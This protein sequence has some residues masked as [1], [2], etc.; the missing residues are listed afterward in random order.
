MI[1]FCQ[2]WCSAEPFLQ[3][4]GKRG[5]EI[6]RS[7][8]KWTMA[9]PA[10]S[11]GFV[12]KSSMSHEIL[13]TPCFQQSKW[14]T[15][16]A[17][18]GRK[19]P[20]PGKTKQSRIQTATWVMSLVRLWLSLPPKV[21]GKAYENCKEI[22]DDDPLRRGANQTSADLGWS[23]SK[24]LSRSWMVR[25]FLRPVVCLLLIVGSWCFN[26]RDVCSNFLLG[27]VTGVS[28]HP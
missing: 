2:R 10:R 5:R 14:K 9:R 28:V 22:G 20:K 26:F 13:Q 21:A 4:L 1:C 6:P 8:A 27:G 17:N 7:A 15:N 3:R 19:T 18:R 23:P 24:D 25:V 16:F 11:G 12:S